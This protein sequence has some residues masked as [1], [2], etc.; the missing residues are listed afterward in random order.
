M[1]PTG[2]G[3]DVTIDPLVSLRREWEA[4][5]KVVSECRNDDNSI[6]V[7]LQYDEGFYAGHRYM[8]F[9]G[10]KSWKVTVVRSVDLNR[11]LDWMA[12]PKAMGPLDD[13]ECDFDDGL[14]MATDGEE[15]SE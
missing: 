15:D 14:D 4:G 3:Y 5:M 6:C 9:D 1:P 2:L 7:A 13:D 8:T 10:C 11:V 12:N